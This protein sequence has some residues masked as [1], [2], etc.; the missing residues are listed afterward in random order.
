MGRVVYADSSFFIALFDSRD[1]AWSIAWE[2]FESFVSDPN[3]RLIF[4]RDVMNELLAHY[5]RSGSSIRREVA[6]FVRRTF[7]DPN[8]S[9]E[10]VDEDTYANALN[11]YESR[12]DKRYSMVDCIGMTIMRRDGLD[13]VVTTD[14]DFVQE[15]FVNLM[16]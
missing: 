6:R 11:L 2:L 5:S 9:V 7:N 10:V 8:Y 4:A 1:D 3:L 12:H 15:G 13:E 14:R 16:R